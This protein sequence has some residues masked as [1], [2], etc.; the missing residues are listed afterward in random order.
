MSEIIRYAP[1]SIRGQL[2]GGNYYLSFTQPNTREIGS[3]GSVLEWFCLIYCCAVFHTQY[4]KFYLFFFLLLN[5]FIVS[6]I[7]L[8]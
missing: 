1:V 4:T 7:W 2:Q 5:I 6:R 8:L 3:C